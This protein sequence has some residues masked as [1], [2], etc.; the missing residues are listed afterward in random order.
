MQ[1]KQ[2]TK[3]RKKKKQTKQTIAID[4]R[5]CVWN[6]HSELFMFVVNFR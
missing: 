6:V 4:P 3:R 5:R 2:Q 1:S